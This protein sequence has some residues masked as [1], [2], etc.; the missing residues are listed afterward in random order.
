[1]TTIKIECQGR[2]QSLVVY[3]GITAIRVDDECIWQPS[4]RL[5]S[6]DG[7]RTLTPQ[8]M[9][10]ENRQLRED[11]KILRHDLE[12]ARRQRDP[13]PKPLVRIT[14]EGNVLQVPN[15]SVLSWLENGERKWRC[16][17]DS[18]CGIEARKLIADWE[19]RNVTALSR[20]NK[21]VNKLW[22]LFPEDPLGEDCSAHFLIERL[23]ALI[24]KNLLVP[25]KKQSA[26]STFVALDYANSALEEHNL[27]QLMSRELGLPPQQTIVHMVKFTREYMLGLQI[28]RNAASDA[29]SE[30]EE[31]PHVFLEHDDG[32]HPRTMAYRTE[33]PGLVRYSRNPVK[34]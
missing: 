30:I 17:V 10:N 31:G 6:K 18:L 13:G 1:M 8:Q 12:W 20:Y 27:I 33:G 29:L 28:Q 7:E 14:E 5:F 11:I 21:C 32:G 3:E 34:P 24:E 4:I 16:A 22:A 2:L 19:A 23:E 26:H 9:V 15:G 25:A